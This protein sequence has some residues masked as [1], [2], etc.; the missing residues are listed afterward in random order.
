VEREQMKNTHLIILFVIGLAGL[1]LFSSIYIVDETEQVV[2]TQFRRVVGEPVTEPGLHFRIPILH[3]PNFFPK[4]IQSWDGEPGEIITQDKTYIWVDTFARWRIIDPVAFITNTRNMPTAQSR[5]SE[6][7]N[8][9]VRDAITSHRLIEAVR[10]SNRKMI[11]LDEMEIEPLEG[12]AVNYVIETGR[13][14]L[15][16]E[17]VL[18]SQPRLE[19][20]GI[21]LLDVKI[22]QINYVQTVRASVYDRMIAERNQMAEFIR[23]EGRGE[24]QRIEGDKEKDHREI[25]SDAYR[26]AEEIRGNA[27]AES[28]RIYADAYN[29]DP[30]FYSFTKTLNVYGT[31]LAGKSRVVLSTDSELLRY[32]K[33][34]STADGRE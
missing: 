14:R 5:L 21:E 20:F 30:E 13:A 1:A 7:I 26:V 27:E 17:I 2:V 24:A 28:T 10:N 23:S 3:E 34:F 25:I 4:N 6:I 22:K 8:P 9:A 31:A 11:P 19:N 33:D 32:L 15:T 16:R 29:I 18:A 12:E